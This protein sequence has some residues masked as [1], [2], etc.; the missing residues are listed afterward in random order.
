MGPAA[1]PTGARARGRDRSYEP[2]VGVRGDELDPREAAGGQIPPEREPAGA[3]LA[4]GD[5]HAED[6]AVPVSVDTGR[7]QHVHRHHTAAFADLQHQRVS[8]DE[9]ERPGV[10]ES[11]GAELFDVLVEFLG[12]HRDLYQGR[13][14]GSRVYFLNRS[15]QAPTG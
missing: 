2:G 9:R 8:G 1:L 10:F 6:L 3:V 13:P 12:H 15:G 7:D 14:S 11:S 5:L 4:G